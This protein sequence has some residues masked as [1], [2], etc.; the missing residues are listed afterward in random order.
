MI[1]R[2]NAGIAKELE[3][4]LSLPVNEFNGFT[5]PLTPV[6]T[7]REPGLI[8][9][10][11][12]GLVPPWATDNSIRQYTLNARIESVEK[13]LTFRDSLKNRCLV[14]ADGFY[15]WQWLDAKGKHKKKYLVTLPGEELYA[16]AGLWNEWVNKSTGEVLKS[17][18]IITTEANPL[19]SKIHNSTLRM[20]VILTPQN[21]H[22]W[23]KGAPVK[24][25][26]HPELDLMARAV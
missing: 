25:F 19:M 26:A 21:E 16:Y 22:E 5:F 9:P 18:T 2:F 4:E 13:K 12:W 24:E 23:L 1:Y 15:E 10:L 8:T 3:T 7:N 6:I 17:Y 11:H 14:I 20:P